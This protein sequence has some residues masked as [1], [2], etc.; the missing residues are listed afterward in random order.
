VSD[1]GVATLAAAP[2][3]LGRL[4]GLRLARSGPGLGAKGVTA[5]AA[6]AGPRPALR[7]SPLTDG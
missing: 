2:G 5:L 1:E 7:D 4:R 6:A 3:L